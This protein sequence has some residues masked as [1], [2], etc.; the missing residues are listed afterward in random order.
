MFVNVLYNN[1]KCFDNYQIYLF[2][3]KIKPNIIIENSKNNVKILMNYVVNNKN[4][5]TIAIILFF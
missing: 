4:S 1:N 2:L 3:D 5:F